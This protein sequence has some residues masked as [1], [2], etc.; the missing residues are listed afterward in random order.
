M[1]YVLRIRLSR[2][3]CGFPAQ[4]GARRV[5]FRPH[6]VPACPVPSKYRAGGEAGVFFTAAGRIAVVTNSL[7]ALVLAGG[8]GTR[9]KSQI[10]K[11]LHTAGGAPLIL[12][13][14]RAIEPLGPESVLVVVG[15]EAEA[16]QTALGG[17]ALRFVRQQPQLGTG[18]ALIVSRSE[19]Q[20]TGT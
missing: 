14:L 8:K 12:H 20:P 7:Q 4:P 16:V 17:H 10:P 3:R 18:H 19:L 15:H 13:V 1:T 5:A 6:L 2:H 11:V 9:L